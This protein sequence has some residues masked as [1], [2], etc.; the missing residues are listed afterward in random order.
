MN[1]ISSR[2]INIFSI[3]HQNFNGHWH[4][5]ASA[6]ANSFHSKNYKTNLICPTLYSPNGEKYD[7]DNSLNPVIGMTPNFWDKKTIKS[8]ISSIQSNR[9]YSIMYDG[10]IPLLLQALIASR[11]MNKDSMFYLNILGASIERRNK[12]IDFRYFIT[13]WTLLIVKSQNRVQILSESKEL[14]EYIQRISKLET[15]VFPVFAPTTFKKNT[16][17]TKIGNLVILEQ[18]EKSD[19][20][21]SEVNN[22]LKITDSNI[23]ITIWTGNPTKSLLDAQKLNNDKRLKFTFGYLDSDSYDLIMQQNFRHIY[24][25]SIDRYEFRTSG[26]LMESIALNKS[27]V[28][29][30]GGT[31][32]G[33]AEKFYGSNF[34][35]FKFYPGD[36][37]SVLLSTPIS[38]QQNKAWNSDKS[39]EE[40][41]KAN[42]FD[43]KSKTRINIFNYIAC[44]GLLICIKL[45]YRKKDEMS[46]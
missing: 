35:K 30:D 20:A 7:V 6:L 22:T 23:E 1:G 5:L 43:Q 41:E 33:L 2:Q 10:R 18:G 24:V 46:K 26:K 19:F 40:L 45:I 25:Y 28:I 11:N 31:F 37:A 15:I 44:I 14:Q 34:Q 9:G 36:L 17:N 38:S 8:F 13:K 29:P 3:Q 42:L 39:V 4:H 16:K 21:I 32:P 12:F 27:L